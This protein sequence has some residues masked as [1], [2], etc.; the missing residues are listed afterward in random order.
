[1]RVRMLCALAAGLAM[2]AIAPRAELRLPSVFSDHMVVQRDQRLTIWGWADPG[3]RVQV[4]LAGRKARAKADDA[5]RWQVRL[6]LLKAG[7]PY[8][9]VVRGQSNAITLSDVLVGEVWICSGQ[10]N[11]EFPLA[12]SRNGREEALAANYPRLR[13]LTVPRKVSDQPLDN[14]QGGWVV[15][16]PDTANRF[17]AVGYFFGRMLMQELDVPVGLINSSWG[18]TPSE[19]WTSQEA[20]AS[21]PDVRPLLDFWETRIREHQESMKKYESEM[22]AWKA[23]GSPADKE[24]KRPVI[25]LQDAPSRLYNGMIA[26]LV[27]FPVRGAIWYQGESNASRAYQYRKIF[28]MMIR[29]WRQAWGGRSLPFGF[30]QL[31]NFLA[32]RPEPGDS[33]WAE[34]REAQNLTLRL[35]NTGMA[36]IYDIGAASNIHPRNKQDVGRR[37]ALWALARVYNQDLPEYSGPRYRSVRVDGA[38]LLVSFIHVDGGLTLREGRAFA[39]AGEDGHFVWAEA[40]VEGERLRVWSPQVPHPVAVRYAWADNP[41]AVL[42]NAAGLPASPFRSDDWPGHTMGKVT[43]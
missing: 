4:Q 15:C 18:G 1:M 38:S 27:P 33:D 8:Q 32:K 35:R 31:A 10:S 39:V 37:L 23:A 2:M 42:Y 16:T 3:E 12:Q 11:M 29:D 30:V 34:L 5:G 26:P 13:L 24:P 7:G 36:A 9:M 19:A 14:F 20:L 6:A 28:P 43:P 41:D 25:W 22:E 40:R 17:T 21:D